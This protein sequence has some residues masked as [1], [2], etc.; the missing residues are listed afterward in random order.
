M[1]FDIFVSKTIEDILVKIE[2]CKTNF[3][4]KFI[5]EKFEK[6]QQ[7]VAEKYPEKDNPPPEKIRKKIEK[8][9]E[10]LVSKKAELPQ[11]DLLI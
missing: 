7:D 10:M 4:W 11:E 3:Q 9:R 5:A 1:L 8:T 2:L 6:L